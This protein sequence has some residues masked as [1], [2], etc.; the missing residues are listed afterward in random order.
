MNISSLFNN[1]A[2]I[3]VYDYYPASETMQSHYFDTTKQSYTI[4]EDGVLRT[5]VN[6]ARNNIEFLDE[7]VIWKYVIQLTSALRLI[8]VAGLACQILNVSKVL[9]S[10][11][12]R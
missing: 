2:L 5:D 8:H 6:M 9:V 12:A 11:R 4:G 10:N 3:V 1:I 7:N